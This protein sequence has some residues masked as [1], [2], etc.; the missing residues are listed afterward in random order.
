MAPPATT[1]RTTL[2]PSP[3]FCIKT[4]ALEPA[5]VRLAPPP[6][7]PGTLDVPAPHT[8]RVPKGIKIF[9]NVAYA[10]GVPPPPP[11]SADAIRRAVAGD[12]F[13]DSRRAEGADGAWFV[14]VVVSEPREERDKAG[15][16][17][18]V[19]DCVYNDGLRARATDAA[20]KTFLIELAFQRIEAQ[21]GVPLSRQIGTPNIAFKGTP[22]P[23][24]VLVPAA[25]APRRAL[26]EELPAS[27]KPPAQ[28][29]R[30][31]VAEEE[32]ATEGVPPALDWTR[33]GGQVRIA[34]KVPRL[35]RADL[36]HTTLDLEA[37]RVRLRS[38]V[39]ALDLDL[40]RPD[41]ELRANGEQGKGMD[42]AAVERVLALKR[43]RDLDVEG[44]RAEWRVAEGVLLLRA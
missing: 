25:L 15:R 12:D 14:P 20:F 30:Q 28:R 36:A 1:V 13:P 7:A 31:I 32:V 5:L 9:V 22:A 42:D 23:R 8:L 17:A 26:V 11:G 40:D 34:L 37:R 29:E 2:T 24:S 18:V 21:S 3:G 38:P 10:A 33:E 27:V 39:Y 35:T 43:V 44:A 41:A 6:S 4:L 19:F 16:P